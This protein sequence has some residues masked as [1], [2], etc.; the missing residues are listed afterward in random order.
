MHTIAYKR[1]F[2]S[3]YSWRRYCNKHQI[4]LGA[5]SMET[6]D[7]LQL[8]TEDNTAA[9]AQGEGPSQVPQDKDPARLDSEGEAEDA[10]V[11]YTG[12]I[13]NAPLPTT[14]DDLGEEPRAPRVLFRSTTGKGIAF[15]REDVQFLVRFLRFRQCV[16]YVLPPSWY[17]M[18][19]DM[20]RLKSA[21]WWSDQYGPILEGRCGKG[22]SSIYLP[23]S[24]QL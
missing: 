7:E 10:D 20:P 11:A 15:T 22:G 19:M 5:Y 1:I 16:F 2:Y 6:P 18:L 8:L 4:R 21:N 23:V 24:D 14:I 17:V 12:E 9:D 3:F 13:E